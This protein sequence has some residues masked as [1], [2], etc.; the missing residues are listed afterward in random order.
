VTIL[1]VGHIDLLLVNRKQKVEIVY[2]INIK[3]NI[4]M[5]EQQSMVFARD[6]YG[7]FVIHTIY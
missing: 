5:G 1:L 3:N 4:P 6:N 2:K 7:K